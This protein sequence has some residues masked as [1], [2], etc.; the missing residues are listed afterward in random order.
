VKWGAAVAAL[1]ISAATCTD[2]TGT[3]QNGGFR[4]LRT[5]T[6]AFFHTNADTAQIDEF[7]SFMDTRLAQLMALY[8]VESM[9]VINV[10]LYPTRASFIDANPTVQSYV[11]GFV[12][13]NSRIEIVSPFAEN[14]VYDLW[15]DT[16]AVHMLTHAVSLDLHPTSA[17]NPRWLWESIAL[18]ESNQ[19]SDPRYVEF[20]AP[21]AEPALDQLNGNAG[22]PIFH[23]GY[24]LGEFI[25]ETWG[26]GMFRTL[27]LAEGNVQSS[28]GLTPAQFVAQFVSFVRTKYQ[29]PS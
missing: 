7:S 14:Q 2:S 19:R 1:I 6:F 29:L 22:S 18:Y 13:G 8:G 20:F 10:F 15:P 23:V 17:N 25:V 11:T 12:R 16:R 4:E 28:L 27:T 3:S 9:P 5:P 21:G 24:L 26:A